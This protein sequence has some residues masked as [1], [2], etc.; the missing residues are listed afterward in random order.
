M[1]D[2]EAHLL[3]LNAVLSRSQKS[4]AEQQA[5]LHRLRTEMA[6]LGGRYQALRTP[7]PAAAAKPLPKSRQRAAFSWLPY[8]GLALAAAAL[9]AGVPEK[10][11]ALAAR[12]GV[13]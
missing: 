6:A 7:P 8:A 10:V 4:L 1:S 13:P 3:L 5:A 2:A 11:A 12:H 9:S